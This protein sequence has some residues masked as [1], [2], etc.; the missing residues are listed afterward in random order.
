MGNDQIWDTDIA[1]GNFSCFAQKK[2]HAS[3]ITFVMRFEVTLDFGKKFTVA[4]H[5]S[6]LDTAFYFKWS[7]LQDRAAVK[8]LDPST[9]IHRDIS[10]PGTF[11]LPKYCVQLG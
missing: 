4:L 10:A 5:T 11:L 3:N 7:Q 9:R 1:A 8:G 6:R 2:L